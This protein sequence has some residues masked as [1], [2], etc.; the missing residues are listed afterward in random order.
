MLADDEDLR[1]IVSETMS[2]LESTENED[3]RGY[4]RASLLDPSAPLFTLESKVQPF[5]LGRETYEL[6]VYLISMDSQPLTLPQSALS[7]EE[8]SIGGISYSTSTSTKFR[9]SNIIFSS[10]ASDDSS[11]RAGSVE[12]IF[13]YTY[14][15]AANQEISE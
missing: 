10:P 6:L 9:D 12:V 14:S 7:V 4:R 8:I 13:W 2:I 1:R 3:A 5:E 15:S 11:S